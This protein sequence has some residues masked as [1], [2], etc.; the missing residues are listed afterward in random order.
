MYVLKRVQK[1][2]VKIKIGWKQMEICINKPK[3]PPEE[4]SL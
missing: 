3:C 1:N 2:T 4:S